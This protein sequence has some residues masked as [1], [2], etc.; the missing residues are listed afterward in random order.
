MKPLKLIVP[1]QELSRTRLYDLPDMTVFRISGSGD[2][3][4]K[5]DFI[6]IARSLDSRWEIFP[7]TSLCGLGDKVSDLLVIPMEAELV[8]K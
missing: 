4:L 5:I 6:M 1:N 8:I 2:Y 7:A 3:Y